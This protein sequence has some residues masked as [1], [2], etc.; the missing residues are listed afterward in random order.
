M[1]PVGTVLLLLWGTMVSVDLI[2]GP[3]IM[4]ARPLVAGTVAGFLVGDP[5]AGVTVGIV[6]ELFALDVL[7][8]G[9]VRY[10]DYGIGAV[11]GAV[12]AAGAPGVLGLGLAVTIGLVI[13]FLGEVGIQ[14]VRRQNTISVRGAQEALDRGDRSAVVRLQYVCVTRDVLKGLVITGVGLLLAGMVRSW[15]FLSVRGAVLLTLGLVGAGLASGIW[16]AVKI[17]GVNKSLVW[18]ATGLLGGITWVFLK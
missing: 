14:W 5:T 12:A 10:A 6:I 15:S 17:G 16:G 1:D 11:A 3:Q 18:F 13:S 9:A 4:I 7:A 8:V 2:T